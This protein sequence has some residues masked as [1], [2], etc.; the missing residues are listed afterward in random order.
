MTT[1][2]NLLELIMNR[3]QQ[4]IETFSTEGIN[5]SICKLCRALV[6]TRGEASGVALASQILASYQKLN[7]EE[8]LN[9]FRGLA[10]QFDVDSDR[11]M[12]AAKRFGEK[13]SSDTLSDLMTVVESPR[14]ELFRRLNLAPGGTATLVS[15]RK[16]L[17]QAIQKEPSL[18]RIDLDLAHLF[19]S[20]FNRGFLILRPIDWTTSAELLEKIIKYEAVHEIGTWEELRRRIQPTDRRCFGFFHPS[21]PDEPLIFVEVALTKEIPSTISSILRKERE[22]LHPHKATTAVFYSISNCQKGL[23]NVSFGSFLIKQVVQE[24]AQNLPH[25]KTFVTLSPVPGFMKWLRREAEVVG[26]EKISELYSIVQQPSWVEN[27]EY[28][29]QLAELLPK[30]AA[31]YLVNAKRSDDWPLDSVTRFHLGNGAIL[32]RINYLADDSLRG[33]KTACG[34]MVNYRYDLSKVESNHEAYAERKKINVSRA[35]SELIPKS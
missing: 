22:E 18:R 31:L 21:M 3:G 30:L 6:S 11:V 29:K 25:L 35:V 19:V 33:L 20:W 8:R 4:L 12:E 34:I 16:D 2:Q 32:H 27:P 5:Q 14:Q 1:L 17:L 15:L 13:N 26:N 28:I 10:E 24:L 23:S 9:F 7:Q